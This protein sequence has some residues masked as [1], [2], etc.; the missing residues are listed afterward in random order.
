MNLRPAALLVITATF[1]AAAAAEHDDVTA[2]IEYHG[3]TSFSNHTS[4][5]SLQILFPFLPRD[6]RSA[7]RGIAIV[8]RPSVRLSV[9]PSVTLAYRRR[10]CWTGS[11]IIIGVISLGG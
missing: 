5:W 2:D 10:M 7:K 11:K 1:A 8:S 4:L 9:C 6:A 3:M